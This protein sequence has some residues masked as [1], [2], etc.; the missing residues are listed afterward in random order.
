MA[1]VLPA[2]IC[3]T[4][5]AAVVLPP[6]LTT[7]MESGPNYRDYHEFLDATRPNW[8]KERAD[9]ALLAKARADDWVEKRTKYLDHAQPGWRRLD[10]EK[11]GALFVC[12]E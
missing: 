11:I 2:A 10:A 3:T 4:V 5:V 7:W 12:Q 9:A 8:R 1:W 6:A